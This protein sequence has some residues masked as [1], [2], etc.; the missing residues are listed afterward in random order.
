MDPETTQLACPHCTSINRVPDAR[1]G[2]DPR[3]GHCQ[4]PL[5]TGLPIALTAANAEGLLL[6]SEQPVV[7]DAWA[8]WC[9]PCRGFA[10]T[11]AAACQRLEPQFRFVT[12]DTEAEPQLAAQFRIQSLPTLIAWQGSRDGGHEVARSS[13]ALPMPQLMQWIARSYG[14]A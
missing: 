8:G 3:C 2:D 9:G 10:P 14:L 7:I 6:K 11:F 12:L 1:M 13:G 4:K 5:F